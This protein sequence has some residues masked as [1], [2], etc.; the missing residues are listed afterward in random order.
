MRSCA[1]SC[2]DWR[3]MQ[4]RLQ[5][6]EAARPPARHSAALPHEFSNIRLRGALRLPAHGYAGAIRCFGS[7]FHGG[8]HG[9]R[10]V[11]EERGTNDFLVLVA[12]LLRVDDAARPVERQVLHPPV[13]GWP[14]GESHR[15]EGRATDLRLLPQEA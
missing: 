12:E 11:L 6:V 2:V 14:I 8:E 1:Y 9:F 13:D 7:Q 5:L 10:P 3:I 15:I 4:H